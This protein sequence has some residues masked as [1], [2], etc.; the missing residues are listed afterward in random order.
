M[1]IK[2][3]NDDNMYYQITTYVLFEKKTEK[4]FLIRN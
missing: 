3:N 2:L 4:K 1:R